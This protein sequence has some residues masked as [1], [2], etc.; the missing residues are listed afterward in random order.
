MTLHAGFYIASKISRNSLLLEEVVERCWWRWTLRFLCKTFG[1]FT[2]SWYF[3]HL[4]SVSSFVSELRVEDFR[5]PFSM[6]CNHGTSSY[7][8]QICRTQMPRHL[9]QCRIWQ[10]RS[11]GSKRWTDLVWWVL[12]GF[13]HG[14]QADQAL[15]ETME[16][17]ETETLTKRSTLVGHR[18]LWATGWWS[19]PME[20]V[21]FQ[22][23]WR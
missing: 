5:S 17:T 3:F 22:F 20:H 9:Y 4:Y 1:D 10:C 15:M 18:F 11:L 19:K 8:F 16:M 7:Y 14:L 6:P 23:S 12:W 2:V 13:G 21:Y